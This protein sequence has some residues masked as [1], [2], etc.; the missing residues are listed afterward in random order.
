MTHAVQDGVAAADI[1]APDFASGDFAS[2][3]IASAR[4]VL[5]TEAEALSALA[6]SLGAAF[7]AAVDSLAGAAGRVVV[8]GMGKS[9]HVGR[10]IAATLASTGT[11]AF[12][13]HP[14]E[15]SHGDLGMITTDDAVVALSNSGETPELSDIVAYT[16][17]FGIPLVAITS[18][19]ES[20][21]ASSADAALILPPIPEAC[22][23]GLAP[24]TS[25]TMMLALGDALAVALLE[26]KEFSA[27]DFRVFH[28][29]GQLGKRLRKVSDLMHGGDGLPLSRLAT[30]MAEVILEMS[31]KSLGCV[32][33]VGDDGR[34]AGII[35]DGDLRR[36]MGDGLMGRPARDIMTPGPRTVPPSMLAAEALG[37][38]N[39]KSITTLLVVQDGRPVGVLHV[40]D[41][42]R[43]GLA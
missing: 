13:V 31:A 42:L 22:P 35:T 29:G 10:K 15:A 19:A 34:L 40:H 14:A 30:P 23:M 21:L 2:G 3:D 16:R 41:L 8:S 25:T 18:R 36:H 28:P 38:M 11:P 24:T 27:A 4:R 1:A 6:D 39:A 5:A 9:G 7:V 37:I 17:R 20:S 26:R 32:A 12:F 33:V 43:S